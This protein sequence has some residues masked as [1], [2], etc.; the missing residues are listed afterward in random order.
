MRSLK[1]NDRRSPLGTASALLACILQTQVREAV[2]KS[3]RN[4]EI[5]Q[6]WDLGSGKRTEKEND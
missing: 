3:S 2:H 6:L 1:L 5:H 4:I